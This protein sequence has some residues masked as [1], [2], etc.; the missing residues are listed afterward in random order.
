MAR[1]PMSPLRRYYPVMSLA[2]IWFWRHSHANHIDDDGVR[3]NAS[4]R[5][6]GDPPICAI[7]LCSPWDHRE[8]TSQGDRE[9]IRQT[10]RSASP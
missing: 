3:S 1:G 10:M 7:T 4:I 5:I 6:P 2:K 8:I 9:S